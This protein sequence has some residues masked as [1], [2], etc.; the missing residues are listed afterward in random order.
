MQWESC[1]ALGAEGQAA[2][3]EAVTP[4]ERRAEEF[5]AWSVTRAGGGT[6]KKISERVSQGAP[7]KGHLRCFLEDMSK[8]VPI[9]LQSVQPMITMRADFLLK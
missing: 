7:K 1:S 2:G 3:M 6:S 4:A 8:C 9:S 5:S